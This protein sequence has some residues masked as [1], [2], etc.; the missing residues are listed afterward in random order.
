MASEKIEHTPGPWGIK[1]DEFDDAWH[2]TP[3]GLEPPKFGEWSPICVLG[4]YHENEEANARL[5]AAAPDLLSACKELLFD[6]FEDVHPQAVKK[7]RAAIKK[8]EG[9]S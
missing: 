9:L 8:A 3:D 5:I 1:F 2:V 7:A 6:A 4:A